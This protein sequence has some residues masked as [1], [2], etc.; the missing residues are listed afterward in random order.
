MKILTTFLTAAALAV[1]ANSAL[2]RDVDAA[3][4][5]KLRDSGTIQTLEKLNEAALATHPGATITDSELENEYGKYIYQ[6][7]LR[8]TQGVD[9][10]L[11][12]DAITGQ[13]YKNHQDN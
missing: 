10:D 3:E 11:E 2:A 13:V 4:A 1:T 7:E 5:Q 8:D 9:W 12:L 6:V